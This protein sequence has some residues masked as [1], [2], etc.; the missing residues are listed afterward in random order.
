MKQRFPVHRN[1]NWSKRSLL[2]VF[3]YT[4]FKNI[5]PIYY[6]KKIKY[7]F[8]LSMVLLDHCKENNFV[9]VSL[10]SVDKVNWSLGYIQWNIFKILQTLYLGTISSVLWSKIIITFLRIWWRSSFVNKNV[11][12]IVMK[13][14]CSFENTQV[15]FTNW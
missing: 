2:N 12:I 8:Y 5:S 11:E 6:H 9:F 13:I 7:S 3:S 1:W 15:L 4:G 10:H 14:C